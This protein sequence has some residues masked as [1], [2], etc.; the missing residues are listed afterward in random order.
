[1]P[2]ETSDTTTN[3]LKP[4]ELNVYPI[5][6]LCRLEHIKQCVRCTEVTRLMIPIRGGTY[7]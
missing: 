4:E 3:C 5:L 7:E 2:Q 6:S 1:M